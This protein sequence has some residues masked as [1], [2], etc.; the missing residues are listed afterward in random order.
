MKCLFKRK[1]Q[2]DKIIFENLLSRDMEEFTTH[3]KRNNE[4]CAVQIPFR[5][6]SFYCQYKIH[7]GTLDR[8]F[9]YRIKFRYTG[10]LS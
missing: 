2:K 1:K 10:K 6:L 3:I 8:T 4:T 7:S 5:P 9:Q